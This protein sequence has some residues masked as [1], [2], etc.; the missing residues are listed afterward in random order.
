MPISIQI[1]RGLLTAQGQRDVLP[2]VAQALIGAHG[3]TGNAFMESTVIGHLSVYDETHCYAAGKAQS[4]A[5]VEVKVP[6]VT[7]ADQKIRDDF[8]TTVTDIIDRLKG[9]DHPK[10]RT[11]VNITYAVEGGWGI[12][13]KAY[14]HADLGAAIASSH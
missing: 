6:G 10:S 12:G 4:L 1:S 3:L 9:S 2:K 8:V 14:T 13:G 5:V 7:F 11:F